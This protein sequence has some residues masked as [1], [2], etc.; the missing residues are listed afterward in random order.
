MNCP[1]PLLAA[2][3]IVCCLAPAAQLHGDPLANLPEDKVQPVI[4]IKARPFRLEDV[5]LLDGPFKHAQ[6]LDKQYL[7]SLD[8]DRLLHN[9]RVNAGIPSNAQPLGGWEEPNVELRGHFEGHYLS[10]C[11]M[12]YASTGDQ[13]LKDRAEVMVKG[14]AECQAKL[15]SSGYLSAFP[16]SFIDR[17]ETTQRVWAPYYTLHKLYAGLLDVYVYCDNQQALD[18]CEKFADWVIARNSKL[19]DQQMQTMLATE[20]GGMNEALANLYALTGDEKYLKISE[21]FNHAAVIGPA[22]NHVDNLTQLHA[23]T[24]IPKFIGTARQ[25]ELTGDKS[26]ES[27]S[28]FFWNTVTNERSYVIGGNSDGE[29]FTAKQRLSEALGRESTETCNTYNMLKLTRHLFTWDPQARYADYYERALFNHILA[30]QNPQ[31]GGMCYY[32][33]LRSGSHKIYGGETDAFWCCTGTGVENHAKYG[34]SVY[35]HDGAKDLWVNLLIAS[36]LK[37]KDAGV[38]LRQETSFPEEGATRLKLTCDKPAEFSLHIRHPFWATR[39]FEIKVNG[40]AQPAGEPGSYA[41]I[42]RTWK[43]GD[44]VD[45]TMPFT[46]RIEAF[47]DNPRR[48]AFMN[49][50]LVLCAAVETENGPFPAVAVEPDQAAGKLRAVEGKPNTFSGSPDLFRIRGGKGQSADVTLEPFYKMHG[51][52]KYVVYF[53]TLTSAAHA[54]DYPVQPVPFTAVHMDDK[55]WAPKIEI[56][57]TVSIP[58][59]FQQCEQTGR[60]DNFIRA[61]QVLNRQTPKNLD[62]PG[63]PFDD[64]D[65]YKV[66]EGASYSLNVHP[67]PKLDAYVDS[68]IDKIAAA[69]EPDG[70]LYTTRTINPAA[71]HEWAGKER[72]VKEEEL[73][74]EL[75]NLGHLYEA[76]VAHYQATGKRTLLDIAIRT[77]NLLDETFGPGKRAIWPGHEITEM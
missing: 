56:N 2:V 23:N 12:M 42:S 19:S 9:F 17:V 21:R 36:E 73:S 75:Y 7:L 46:A 8:P 4:P 43:S 67:D 37:W 18:V 58:T 15:G 53:D 33:P 39:G 63:Y 71:P 64:T 1:R 70:Y 57:R 65:I 48:F 52:R 3:I 34:D 6:E 25:Y 31:T 74:H 55:F 38:V 28:E 47:R 41:I 59:A 14:L 16:E 11:A 60:V 62:P 72:W 49:G 68:L 40:E 32:V 30:S 77:A 66:I 13:R 26:L 5:R 50:P 61:A 45:V 10:A 29:R 35:F 76:A 24:Q 22:S 44:T 51:E 69:Q 54:H 27:A 20:H